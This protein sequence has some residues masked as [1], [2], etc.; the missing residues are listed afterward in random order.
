[1]FTATRNTISRSPARIFALAL[2]AA[3]WL[4]PRDAVAEL[5]ITYPRSNSSV[6]GEVIEIEGSGA[7]PG[8]VIEVSVLTDRWYPQDGTLTVEADG[9]WAYG[10]CYLSGAGTFNRHSIRARL[11]EHGQ[12]RATARV[13]E[14]IRE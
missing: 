2:L 13:R 3:S 4:G 8:A 14:V 7:S 6:R 11:I 9:T 10:P 12:V 5:E 1:M